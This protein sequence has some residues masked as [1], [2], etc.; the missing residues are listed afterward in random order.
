M[1]LSLEFLVLNLGP[2]LLVIGLLLGI[3][4]G[5]WKG[6]PRA[7]APQGTASGAPGGLSVIAMILFGMLAIYL[8]YEGGRYLYLR[9]AEGRHIK[10]I[11]GPSSICWEIRIMEIPK[12]HLMYR[13]YR[14]NIQKAGTGRILHRAQLYADPVPVVIR[15]DEFWFVHNEHLHVSS[16]ETGE[17]LHDEISIRQTFGAML[18]NRPRTYAFVPEEDAIWVG[19]DDHALL[20]LN[21]ADRT[22]TP[23]AGKDMPVRDSEQSRR[24]LFDQPYTGPGFSVEPAKRY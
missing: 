14:A 23:L 18:F 20:R 7:D 9:Y 11:C 24:I 8:A 6:K 12:G 3:A 4:F 5:L 17:D 21:L 15:G 16:W 1:V 22:T 19:K 10:T 2:I 13:F